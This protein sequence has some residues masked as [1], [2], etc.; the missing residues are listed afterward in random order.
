MSSKDQWLLPDGIEE[1]LPP[2]A[3]RLE[4]ARRELLDM[5]AGRGYD[6]INLEESEYS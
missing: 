6:L 4:R 3:W 2:E 1:V 5:F